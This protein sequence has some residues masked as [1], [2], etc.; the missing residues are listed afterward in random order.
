MDFHFL[1]LYSIPISGH[2]QLSD[3]LIRNPPFHFDFHWPIS[4][5]NLLHY[6]FH[7]NNLDLFLV[8]HHNFLN[9]DLDYFLYLL[10]NNVGHLNLYDLEN[11][12][13]NYNYLLYYLWHFNY[14]LDDSGNN[15][16]FLNYFLDFNHPRYLH[17]LLDNTLDNL[18]LN[19]YNLFLNH[20]R[21]WFFNVNRL[22][23]LLSHWNNLDDLHLELFNFLLDVRHWNLMNN[24]DLFG[25]V[26]RNNLLNLNV[27]G[28]Q[29]FMNYWLVNKNLYFPNHLDLIALNEMRP[30]NKHLLRSFSEQLFLL[31]YRYLLDDFLILFDYDWLVSILDHFHNIDLGYSNLNGNF[32]LNV[33]DLFMFDN[34]RHSKFYFFILS[35]FDDLGD[36]NLHFLHVLTSFIQVDWLLDNL[37]DLN[38][39][40]PFNR[41]DL[42]DLLELD[43]INYPFDLNLSNQ[44]LPIVDGNRFLSDC[45]HFN[46]WLDYP[47]DCY[48]PINFHRYC[49]LRLNSDGNVRIDNMINRLFNIDWNFSVDSDNTHLLLSQ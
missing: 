37:L 25:N 33:N 26:Q 29:Y 35:L 2:C 23:Y 19:P 21:H 42:L 27:F 1:V 6:S 10:N 14:P 13:L 44:L 22:N 47:L 9:D 3:Y 17:N 40:L 5:Y 49:S 8:L 45:W 12:L 38:V 31:R 36:F 48:F 20:H 28:C 18:L 4:F 11:R 41:N 7:F 30:L 32:S 46:S 34:V 43:S 39:L 24:W 16:N 15:H